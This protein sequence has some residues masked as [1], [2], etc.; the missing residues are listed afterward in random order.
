MTD[1]YVIRWHV[2]ILYRHNDGLVDIEYDLAEIDQLNALIERGPHWD[3]IVEIKI[4]RVNHNESVT[5][6]VEEAEQL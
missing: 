4:V 1:R 5:L 3:T 2:T 6:T